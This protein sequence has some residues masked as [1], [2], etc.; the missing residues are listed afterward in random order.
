MYV[1]DCIRTQGRGGILNFSYDLTFEV[2][3][4]ISAQNMYMIIVPSPRDESKN[5]SAG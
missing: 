1:K 4:A 3:R 2:S 5:F